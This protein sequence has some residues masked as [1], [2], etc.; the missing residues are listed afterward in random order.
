MNSLFQLFLKYSKKLEKVTLRITD[1]NFVEKINRN[2]NF[3]NNGI[4]KGEMY[5]NFNLEPY[6]KLVLDA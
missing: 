1:A 6:P 2:L 3:L 4:G 5:K